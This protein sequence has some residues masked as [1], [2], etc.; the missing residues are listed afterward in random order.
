MPIMLRAP[1]TN[2]VIRSSNP[3]L[4][5]NRRLHFAKDA[6][7]G[8]LGEHDEHQQHRGPVGGQGR[9]KPFHHQAPHQH[10]DGQQKVVPGLGSGPSSGSS[11]ISCGVQLR[12]LAGKLE[13]QKVGGEQQDTDNV[14]GRFAGNGF[15]PAQAVI[16]DAAHD[17]DE[18]KRHAQRKSLCRKVLVTGFS[19]P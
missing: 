11:S 17:D 18:E 2:P 8:A 3:A 7:E 5:E 15:D 12:H 6:F 13:Q 4:K 16:G 10:H 1:L 14:D 19:I 9:R